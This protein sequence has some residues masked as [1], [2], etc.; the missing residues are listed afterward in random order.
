MS[1]AASGE[2]DVDVTVG[3]RGR[4]GAVV[5]FGNGVTRGSAS[6]A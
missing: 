4:L 6:L 3:A 5:R 2:R 1:A